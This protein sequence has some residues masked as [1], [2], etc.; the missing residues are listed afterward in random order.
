MANKRN[1]LRHKKELYYVFLIVV[2]GG[3][4][5]FSF[6]GPDG[7]LELNDLQLKVQQQKAIVDEL[8]I[9]NRKLAERTDS[10]KNDPVAIEGYAREEGYGRENEIIQ[11]L[12]EE[13]EEKPE[14][15]SM[16]K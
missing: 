12:P 5:L 14:G 13:P 11:Q 2:V 10:L 3:I 6:F 4:L 7:Y 8:E 16:K 15:E 1:S 9:S